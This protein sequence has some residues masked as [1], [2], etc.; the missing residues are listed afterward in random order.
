MLVQ[1]RPIAPIQ[2]LANGDHGPCQRGRLGVVE[3]VA[4]AGR[5]E[6]GKLQVRQ[7]AFHHVLHQGEVLRVVQP[8]PEH[9]GA[10]RA[11]RRRGFRMPH[12]GE[13]IAHGIEERPRGLRQRHL[14]EAEPIVDDHVQRRHQRARA[15][16][17]PHAR[18]RG[19]AFRAADFA[20][21]VHIDHRL[22]VGVDAGTGDAQAGVCR[23]LR[24][25]RASSSPTR[26]RCS[27]T[28]A[29]QPSSRCTRPRSVSA[30]SGSPWVR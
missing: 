30:A 13:G 29:R 10:D 25:H 1:H 22:L 4:R 14:V 7:P 20:V 16:V 23:G 18:H 24:D 19:K 26:S 6:S 17:Q 12:P 28:R 27:G 15:D 21:T 9:L 5:D 8:C 2:A 11:C 3:A